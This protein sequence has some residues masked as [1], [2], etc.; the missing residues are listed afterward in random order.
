VFLKRTE[1]LA[2]GP[3]GVGLIEEHFNHVRRSLHASGNVKLLRMR[4]KSSMVMALEGQALPGRSALAAAT[5]VALNEN[6]DQC[7]QNAFGHHPEAGV[8]RIRRILLT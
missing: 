6:A 3:G 5:N 8:R 4:S 7:I 1:R 2:G